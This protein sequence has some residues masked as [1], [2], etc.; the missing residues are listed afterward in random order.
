MHSFSEEYPEW[1]R[2]KKACAINSLHTY[3]FSN[4]Y[5]PYSALSCERS[6]F[7]LHTKQSTKTIAPHLEYIFIT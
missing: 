1:V 5:E 6:T 3:Y 4:R 2:S 7:E